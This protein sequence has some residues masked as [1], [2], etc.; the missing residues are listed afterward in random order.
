MDET[1]SWQQ[2]IQDGHSGVYRRAIRVAAGQDIVYVQLRRG[3]EAV[4]LE[5]SLRAVMPAAD[6]A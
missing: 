4:S 3:Q 5:F 6:S 1:D 2:T